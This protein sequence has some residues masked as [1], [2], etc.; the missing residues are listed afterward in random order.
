MELAIKAVWRVGGAEAANIYLGFLFG[1]GNHSFLAPCLSP[2]CPLLGFDI[3]FL[4]LKPH[5]NSKTLEVD[6]PFSFP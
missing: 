6:W 4:W 2:L 1:S 3:A 5:L